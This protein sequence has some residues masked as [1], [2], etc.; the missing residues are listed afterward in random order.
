MSVRSL[1]GRIAYYA[2][3]EWIEN[4]RALQSLARHAATRGRRFTYLGGLFS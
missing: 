4:G 1:N 2:A 3:L